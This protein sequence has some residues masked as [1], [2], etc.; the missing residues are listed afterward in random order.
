MLVAII[1]LGLQAGTFDV[2]TL[3][4]SGTSGSTWLFLAFMAAFAI[5]A[6]LYPLHGWVPDAYRESS[7]E[8]AAL[9]SGVIS[10]AGTYG[11]LRFA[12]PLFPGPAADWRVPFIV[13]SLVG[14]LWGSL[15]AFRQP[16]SRGV[17]AYSSIAQSG[18]IC[19]GIFVLNDIG[20]TGATFQMV[21]HA[22][23]LDDPVPDR[24]VRR[25]ALRHRP[26]RPHRRAG[27]RPARAGDDRDVHRRRRAGGAR[28]RTCSPPSSWC[29]WA[30]SALTGSSARWP[31]WRIVLA[32]MYMLRWISAVLHDP[33]GDATLRPAAADARTYP[34]VRWE[35]VYLAPLIV[36]VL[37][38]SA[39]PYLVTHRV[40]DDVGKLTAPAALVANR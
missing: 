27:P 32:A 4:T 36:A 3:E 18:M 33:V 39:Y 22:H 30:R 15:M 26:L 37:V 40:Q 31:R 16:D 2:N 19:L 28:A 13:L 9:L 12:L 35:A 6:P 24:R 5:K 21:N 34:D 17:I 1:T 11:M 8:V 29:C 14:L 38:L 25:G 7:P 10:K 20:A 23:P